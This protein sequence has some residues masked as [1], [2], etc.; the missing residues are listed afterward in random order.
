MEIAGDVDLEIE[1]E[2]RGLTDLLDRALGRLPPSARTVLTDHYAGD[3]TVQEMAARQGKSEGAITQRLHR[4]RQA[5]KRVLTT[6]L[7]SEAAVYGLLEGVTVQWQETRIWCCYCGQAKLQIQCDPATCS[8]AARCAVCSVQWTDHTAGH[9]DE[10]KGPWRTMLRMT[11]EAHRYYRGALGNGGAWCAC[12]GRHADLHLAIPPEDCGRGVR[13]RCGTCGA[14]SYQPSIGLVLTLPEV[15]ILWRKHRR[16]RVARESEVE[17]LGRPAVVTSLETVG[18]ASILDVV[19]DRDTFQV[20]EIRGA[21][22]EERKG[23]CPK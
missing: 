7:R 23:T 20:L 19:S 4:G 9:L 6:D 18:N 1:V 12:C 8:F 14:V 13:L 21:P 5:L 11:R 22:A 17:Y 3:L 2:R 16:I 10:V 15:E